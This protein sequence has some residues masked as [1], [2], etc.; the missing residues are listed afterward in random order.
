[1]AVNEVVQEGLGSKAQRAVKPH[2]ATAGI[3][4]FLTCTTPFSMAFLPYFCRTSALRL[5]NI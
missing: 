3:G 2:G 1:M 4:T 5:S